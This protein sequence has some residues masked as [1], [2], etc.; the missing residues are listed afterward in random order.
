MA[1]NTVSCFLEMTGSL[2]SFSSKCLPITQV[3]L[4][5][6][7]L[8]V[9]LSSKNVAS[10]KRQ[11]VSGLNSNNCTSSFFLF[12]HSLSMEQKCFM[13]TSHLIT[14]NIRKSTF[15]KINNFSCFSFKWN[16]LFFASTWQNAVIGSTVRWHCLHSY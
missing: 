14:Q 3:W 5:M 11:L 15:N 8:P 7:Y 9:V 2:C 6:V 13:R 16:W 10:W 1:T 4:T 12:K